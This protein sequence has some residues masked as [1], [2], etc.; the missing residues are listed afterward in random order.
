[1]EMSKKGRSSIVFLGIVTGILLLAPLVYLASA[2]RV[3]LNRQAV[4]R[5]IS[6]LEKSSSESL[7][8]LQ[9]KYRLFRLKM[10]PILPP[11]SEVKLNHS[12]GIVVFDPANFTAV[13][14][15]L[16]P[17][18]LNGVTVYPVIVSEDPESRNTVFCNGHAELIAIVE[19]EEDYD[20]F[21][22]L[23]EYHPEYY[24]A[25]ADPAARASAEAIYDPSRLSMT[26]YLLSVEDVEAMAA[27]QVE[28][29][30]TIGQLNTMLMLGDEP[31][32]PVTN[33]VIF[34]IEPVSNGIALGIAWPEDFTNKLE[35]FAR[36]NIAATGWFLAATNL[37]T[38]GSNSLWWTD[39]DISITS[40]SRF[41][42][43]GNADIDS[44]QDG[45]AN[46]QERF[47]YGTSETNS[48]SDADGILDKDEI[49]VYHTGPLWRDT[50]GDQ[51]WDGWEVTNNLNPLN[52]QDSGVDSDSDELVNLQEYQ[53]KS[54]P[55]NSDTD[56]DG[57]PDGWEYSHSLS[58]TNAA[59]ARQDPDSDG[60]SNRLEYAYGCDPRNDDT[61]FDGMN[62]GAEIS[63]GT[64]PLNEDTDGDGLLDGN[65]DGY[66]YSTD[67]RYADTD[68]D[69]LV[70][71]A[72]GLVPISV[73]P[74]GIDMNADGF[75]DADTFPMIADRDNDGVTDGDEL[76]AGSDPGSASSTKT[77]SS[78]SYVAVRISI[79]DLRLDDDGWVVLRDGNPFV[80]NIGKIN[81]IVSRTLYVKEG[82]K[83]QFSL[84]RIEIN[85]SHGGDEYRFGND[86]LNSISDTAWVA[87]PDNSALTGEL[88][89]GPGDTPP[90]TSGIH[91]TFTAGSVETDSKGPADAEYG[92]PINLVSGAM[93][94]NETDLYIPCP[95][96]D[97]VLKRSYNNRFSGMESGFG[98]GWN[99]SL[100]WRIQ[101]Y[102][103][104]LYRGISAGQWKVLTM[105]DD[106]QHWFPST[107]PNWGSPFDSNLRLSNVVNGLRLYMAGGAI[108]QFNTNGFI[109]A[110]SN[111][112]GNQLSYIYSGSG[113]TQRLSRVE[114]GNGQFLS[115]S[116]SNN[117]LI[118]AA[119]PIADFHFLYGWDEATNLVSATR[120]TPEGESTVGYSYGADHVSLTQRVNRAGD[121]FE[122]RYSYY[123]NASGKIK[124]RAI[125]MSVGA[126]RYYETQMVYSENGTNRAGFVNY[127][128]TYYWDTT[129]NPTSKL[130]L[131]K[132]SPTGTEETYFYSTNRD[133]TKTTILATD[134]TS[135]TITSRYD[136]SHRLIGTS[137]GMG[138]GTTNEWKIGW[139]D[140][141][142]L[143]AW[144]EDPEGGRIEFVYTNGLPLKE[145]VRGVSGT[146]YDTAYYYD[147]NGLMKA[148][149]NANGNGL[150]FR[151]DIYGNLDRVESDTAPWVEYSNNRLGYAETLVLQDGRT[152]S[153]DVNDV[154]WLRGVVWPDGE[155]EHFF[156]DPTGNV[157]G[158]VDRAGRITRLD[159]LPTGK[160]AGV[161][162][163]LNGTN[164]SV[165]TSYDQQFNTVN[166]QDELG[167]LVESYVLDGDNHI[168]SVTNLEG[169]TETFSYT[170]GDRLVW[171]S[172]FDGSIVSNH[173][174]SNGWL[175]ETFYPDSS[176]K[177]TYLRNGLLRTAVNES[178][179][180]SNRYDAAQ[181][182]V[183]SRGAGP[184]E[185][186]TY[187]YLPADQVTNIS[188]LGRSVSALYDGADR[189]SSINSGSTEF[190]YRYDTNSG[191]MLSCSNTG[192]SVSYGFNNM[193][194]LTNMC[195]RD[196]LSETV[197]S[198]YYGLNSNGLIT[199]MVTESGETVRYQLD[200][201]D[202]LV[203]EEWRSVG[204]DTTYSATYSYDLTGNRIQTVING[205]TNN[206][207]SGDGNRLST[208]GT[209][210]NALYDEAGC[211]TTLVNNAS[212]RIDL[213]WNG[214]YELKDVAVNGVMAERYGYDGL[215]RRVWTWDGSVTNWHIY[216]GDQVI[217]D[218][219]SDGGVLR[220]YVWGKG[221]DNLLAM[222]VHT[223]A[224]TVTYLAVK[225]HLGSVHALTDQDG[226]IIESYRFDAWG[227]ILAVL[228]SSGEPITSG[229]SQF[230]NRYLWQGRE[231][232]WTTGL[233][234][235]RARWYDPVV[236]R[237]L[238][239]DPIGISGGLNQYVFCGNDPIN[240]IDPF[241]DDPFK[242]SIRADQDHAWI[243]VT[244][245]AD[246]STHTYGRWKYGY[247]IP[248]V[249][250]SGVIIDQE[251]RKNIE[252]PYKA[253]RS[254]MVKK[255]VPT[256]NEGYTVYNDNCATYAR[257]EWKRI[258]GED[259]DNDAWGF[260]LW[261]SP[262]VLME[263]ILKANGGKTD[264]WYTK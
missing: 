53:L 183:G 238:S 196:A 130:T 39:T 113:A 12:G 200:D 77:P 97:I 157:T 257:D 45:I 201:L 161:V 228:D 37:P 250:K 209:E 74:A 69:G 51:M 226:A 223:G 132:K 229:Q 18:Q 41:Y 87:D 255:F 110:I 167:R 251:R 214:R 260:L 30:G 100:N 153:Y 31:T 144:T 4:N 242:V 147:S 32:E 73:Y 145:R 134:G 225:D 70:D 190:Q 23:V 13:T 216:D 66:G 111:A 168:T 221:I 227:N 207:T 178:G 48:D 133:K 125:G 192:L 59:D 195:W 215:G 231:Y 256:I 123:T 150:R 65:E 10:L 43:I 142:S 152:T 72:D 129:F 75:V 141:W 211:T 206:Y 140:T 9:A 115:F 162:R 151:H 135:F 17:A 127:G 181:R 126:N 244:D 248:K 21:A 213:R 8:D 81:Q 68:G 99:H 172:R 80:S 143:P 11:D 82:Q 88:P 89:Y 137:S 71:G 60:L 116:Y 105:G 218:T 83:V 159:W 239:L 249:N 197:R 1:M 86:V 154:G 95:G 240:K 165:L 264:A 136:S 63:W 3:S 34:A 64:D 16:E 241:G 193:D 149:T 55:W 146:F 189:L 108:C 188:F 261:D 91:W 121:A 176:E 194:W 185:E 237:W 104:V 28:A 170:V 243:S 50:D 56:S 14:G 217:A 160:L 109:T 252:R 44:D 158:H 27:A 254:R 220:T 179:M 155:S 46:A 175:S 138:L 29:S 202:R 212:C 205:I 15:G 54:N 234:Y 222:T 40:G 122:Y 259:L 5:R 236:G 106:N 253:S 61:D 84:R 49:F 131:W 177:Y 76:L 36:T 93:R 78:N 58:L 187:G 235:F 124:S 128:S 174:E 120:V 33:L 38:S 6:L 171:M 166:V 79:S 245:I 198:F 210:G 90:D 156:Y 85:Q 2:A 163:M 118:K 52:S 22:W 103:G 107:G 139:N 112:V 164:V 114:H 232:S 26:F 262:V 203:G 102:T 96:M 263:S 224:M 258:T 230:G 182:I 219:D 24:E 173:Y 47:S 119:T 246:G 35:V 186:V 92:D 57:M 94:L 117:L 67:P 180:V 247:G 19:P 101:T 148:M 98:R 25:N 191:A 208:F 233:Y 62:D 204:G 20:P 184:G 42:R 169:Q 199:N 7:S